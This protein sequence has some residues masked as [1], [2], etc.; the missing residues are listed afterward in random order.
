[1]GAFDRK[2]K[3][4]KDSGASVVVASAVR[5]PLD[6]AA[7][8]AA[9][10]KRD[11]K[12]Q[13]EAW[14]YYDEVGEIWFAHNF[15][16]NFLSR[17]RIFAAL[18]SDE[19]QPPDSIDDKN[20]PANV[21][22]GRLEQGEGTQAMLHMLGVNLGVPGEAIL[23]GYVDKDDGELWGVYSTD[24]IFVNSRGRWALKTDPGDKTGTE[25]DPATTVMIRIWRNHPRWKKLP[26]SP[27]RPLL[28]LC[29]ELQI[30]SRSIR[31]TG[32][33]RLAG[34][35]LLLWPK[36]AVPE[37]SDPSRQ[38]EPGQDSFVTEL[39]EAMTTPIG[40]EGSAAAVVPLVVKM[41][42]E[43]IEKVT[44]LTFDR[45]MDTVEAEQR[46]EVISRISYG[47]DIP[48]EVLTGTK[49]LNHWSAWLIDEQTFK[50]H[51]EPLILTICS[52]MTQS[53]L[54][55]LLDGHPDQ[56]RAIVW[57]DASGLLGHPNRAQDAKD[58]HASIAL[59]DDA[60][61]R[62]LGFSDEDAPDD[63]ELERRIAVAKGS[64][65]PATVINLLQAAGLLQG[66]NPTPP[67]PVVVPASQPAIDTGSSETAPADQK[68]NGPPTK[69]PSV[70][71]AGLK[72]R[73]TT[74]N[75]GDA[76]TVMDRELRRRLIDAASSAVNR[77]L[78]R[79][80]AKMRRK[81]NAQV[82]GALKL[83]ANRD[84]MMTVG[85]EAAI[86]FGVDEQAIIDE[87]LADLEN[88]YDVWVGSTQAQVRRLAQR[89]AVDDAAVD[90]DKV[91]RQQDDDRHAGWLLLAGALG[92]IAI[93]RMFNPHPEAPALG[94]TDLSAFV[95]MGVIRS[96]LA[97]AGGDTR[98]TGEQLSQPVGGVATGTEALDL[99]VSVGLR[100]S[101]YTWVYGDAGSR[102]QP[103]PAHEDLDG[104][105]FD[106]F[107]DPVL[108][109]TF[110][111]PDTPTLFPGDH[112]GCQCDF[113][114]GIEQD[115]G[116]E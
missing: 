45:A 83:V 48:S 5:V 29:D 109:N 98:A 51:L 76:L 115:T 20:H 9:Y 32:R 96:S 104:V 112:D 14:R 107:D 73:S 61:R 33:S 4:L 88:Q 64:L 21:E 57:Y 23:L 1:M 3:E 18:E 13:P 15:V 49:G 113:E 38:F 8:R 58:A 72:L 82:T 30:L 40:D 42:G 35:G 86:A 17:I 71:A 92:G 6:D 27:M 74:R 2:T 63:A 91:Q 69:S 114:V 110:D 81:A 53:Y 106:S 87:E 10:K 99:F 65:D 28:G 79:A 26:D 34:A 68:E 67:A 25:L 56:E 80:G 55:P 85:Q 39:I 90:Y 84:V 94:E 36:E 108:T 89:W 50:A 24:Q 66:V 19:D 77:A 44:R 102:R 54:K 103:F 105:G 95:P 70:Q 41:A 116:G 100:T 101:E 12:W 43:H 31:S 37:P 97:R 16:G 22:M 11:L 75:R 46:K 47:L 52:A 59:S 62:Y 111:Y 60:L 93:D 78:D 7:V